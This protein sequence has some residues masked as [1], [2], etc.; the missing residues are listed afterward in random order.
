MKKH[1]DLFYLLVFFI[2]FAS[3]SAL[4]FFSFR[5]TKESLSN[6]YLDKQVSFVNGVKNEFW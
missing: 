4:L 2:I 3:L 6:N 5:V 1:K